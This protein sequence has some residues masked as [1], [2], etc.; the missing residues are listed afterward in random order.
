VGL[1]SKTVFGREKLPERCI[2]YAGAYLPSRKNVVSPLFAKWTRLKGTWVR[3]SF[4]KS[5]GRPF[6]VLFNVYGAAMML[7]VLQLLKDGKAKSVFFIGS[8]GAKRLAIGQLVVP[9]EVVDRAGIVILDDNGNHAV[10]PA[11]DSLQKLTEALSERRVDYKMAKV[12][13]VPAVLHGI[14]SILSLSKARSDIEGHEMELST[15]Y[16][17]S[18]KL[19]LEAYA[20][21]YVSDNPRHSIIDPS[22]SVRASRQ[23]ALREATGIAISVLAT[24]R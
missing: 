4:A 23:K 3:Y 7:E 8:I 1:F 13:S 14:E 18:K 20:L 5:D 11:S 21:V 2:I 17:F 16:H 19:G 10:A 6:L 22:L 15:F 9:V 12:M 24:P